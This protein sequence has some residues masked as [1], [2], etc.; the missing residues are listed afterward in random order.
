M[1]LF[2]LQAIKRLIILTQLPPEGNAWWKSL[3]VVV[4]VA[5]Y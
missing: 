3:N 5:K 2:K 1:I 4:I